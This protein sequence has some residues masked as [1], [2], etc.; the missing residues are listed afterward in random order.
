MALYS[1]QL[2]G[3]IP[4]EL[5]NL[6]ALTSLFL[7]S[8]QLSG[9][10]PTS[11]ASLSNLTN[12]TLMNND[13][14]GAIPAELGGLTRLNTLDLRNNRLSGV[15]PVMIGNLTGL[16]YL[17][18]NGNMLAG[19]VPTSLTSLTLLS[20]TDIGYNAL[21][22]SD[23]TL[24]TFLNSKDADWA[25]TQTIAPTGVTAEAVDGAAV[26]VS[27]TPIPFTA[28]NGYYKIYHAQ[29]AGGPYGLAGQTANK[30]ASSF[31]VSG[32][33]HGQPYYFVVQTHTD[34]HQYN[35]Y[36]NNVESEYSAEVTATPWLQVDIRV[37]GTITVGGSPLANVVWP[38]FPA[39]P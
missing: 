29:S 32:L 3:P 10:I 38:G 8:N 7:S 20:Y 15:I 30:S 24:I 35:Y 1:N 37:A 14:T 5:G 16:R 9:T 39:I 12:L 4:S 28:L 18:L 6:T 17:Y 23:A 21:Y 22:T 13:L 19:P 33:N 27:W 11:L 31:E 36:K 26:L 25:S 2:T 34:P